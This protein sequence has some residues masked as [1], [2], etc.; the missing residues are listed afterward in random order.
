MFWINLPRYVAVILYDSI[1]RMKLP[2]CK[3]YKW[4]LSRSNCGNLRQANN[5]K[6]IISSAVPT[7][8]FST[9]T[10]LSHFFFPHLHFTQKLGLTNLIVNGPFTR[11]P[12]LEEQFADQFGNA[13]KRYHGKSFEG[14]QCA[15]FLSCSAFMKEVVPSSVHLL[16]EFLEALHRVVVGVFG[17]NLDPGFENDIS[18]FKETF[19][20]SHASA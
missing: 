20:M 19:I 6:D 13:R 18:T 12:N 5:R 11:I 7:P 8:L 14:R 9:L 16:V 3:F 10:G 2:S 15:K 1:W 17:Q 4:I